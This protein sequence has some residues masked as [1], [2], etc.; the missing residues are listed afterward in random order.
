MNDE[1]TIILRKS[2]MSSKDAKSTQNVNRALATG[3]AEITK[4]GN[5][6]LY[7]SKACQFSE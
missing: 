3:N 5:S 2:K 4:K 7:F 6:A 1:R